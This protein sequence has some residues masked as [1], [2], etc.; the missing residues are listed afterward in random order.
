M[1]NFTGSKGGSGVAQWLINLM[2]E[3]RV[4]VEPFL[5]L[6]VVMTTKSMAAVNIGIDYD[7]GNVDD[8]RRR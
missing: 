5:G 8:Y 7:A 1:K 6:G 3:H 4:Y 2:P